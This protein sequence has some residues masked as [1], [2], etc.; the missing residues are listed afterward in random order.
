LGDCINQSTAK[1]EGK[2]K[3]VDTKILPVA[4]QLICMTEGLLRFLYPENDEQRNTQINGGDYSRSRGITT[5]KIVVADS[6][7]KLQKLTPMND[8]Y[9]QD[10]V[11]SRM[12]RPSRGR[13]RGS[14]GRPRQGNQEGRLTNA[15][16]N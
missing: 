10:K 5:E 12:A 3:R 9:Q 11:E 4:Q 15:P 7:E 14:Q 1:V 2:S 16:S 13:G 8:N 6:D